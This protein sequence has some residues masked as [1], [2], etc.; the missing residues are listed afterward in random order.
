LRDKG[1]VRQYAL[2]ALHR[3]TTV[4]AAFAALGL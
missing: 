4:D 2:D 1:F 3:V